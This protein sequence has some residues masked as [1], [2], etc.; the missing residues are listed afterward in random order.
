MSALIDT[1]LPR[2][3]ADRVSVRD[4][5][6]RIGDGSFAP[7]L[8]VVA[9]ILV[10]PLSAIP[11]MPTL[12]GVTILLIAVQWVLG[13]HHLWLPDIL[14]RRSIAAKRMLQAVR[15]LRDPAVWIDR[16]THHR[17]AVLT[18]QPFKLVALLVIIV[19]A[20]T[21]P[22]LE[23][24]P[25]FT[26]VSAFAVSLFAIGLMTRDGAFVVA[27]YVFVAASAAVVMAIWRG[28]V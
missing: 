20:A 11:G 5:L 26:S 19:T 10:S 4:V 3:G 14:M 25:M 16:H 2:D 1:L 27:G 7:A 24:L 9:L 8:L 12:G 22:F 17:L 15:F 28:L 6:E 13:R 18:G 21:W 23:L